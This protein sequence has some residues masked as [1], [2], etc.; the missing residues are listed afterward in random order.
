[1]YSFISKKTS[2]ANFQRQQLG[3]C[4]FPSSSCDTPIFKR[5][6]MSVEDT[7]GFFLWNL[8][9]QI[10]SAAGKT[11][12]WLLLSRRDVA[13]FPADF[14]SSGHSHRRAKELHGITSF[15]PLAKW[16][17]QVCSASFH[18]PFIVGTSHLG[19]G[20]EEHKE[21]LQGISLLGK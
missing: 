19:S 9:C 20:K 13:H 18:F 7:L 14:Q 17:T 12:P 16:V 15:M 11:L 3:F 1:M 10:P 2:V 21:F 4:T 5:L 8:C 6:F